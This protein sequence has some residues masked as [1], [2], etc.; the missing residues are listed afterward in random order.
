LGW[1]KKRKRSNE[2][3]QLWRTINVSNSLSFSEP[4]EQ[5]PGPGCEERKI[6]LGGAPQRL[7][8]VYWSSGTATK[9]RAPG[10]ENGRKNPKSRGLEEARLDGTGVNDLGELGLLI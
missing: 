1:E 3:Y 7:E 8:P 9:E 2:N 5:R 4:G 6:T 10:Y